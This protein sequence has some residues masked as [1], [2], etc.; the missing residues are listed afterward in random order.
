MP[1]LCQSHILPQGLSSHISATATH[2]TSRSHMPYLCQSYILPQGLSFHISAT[3]THLTSRSVI[4]HLSPSH[5][6]DLKASH[7]VS[8]SQSHILAQVFPLTSQS[9]LH[10]LSE[11]RKS[12]GRRMERWM[13]IDRVRRSCLGELHHS[14]HTHHRRRTHLFSLGCVRRAAWSRCCT[15]LLSRCYTLLFRQNCPPDI[16]VTQIESEM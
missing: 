11:N 15:S 16:C 10:T 5:T 6:S 3:A 4:P 1:Y 12:A 8:P 14:A 9:E 7:A 2:L 13:K